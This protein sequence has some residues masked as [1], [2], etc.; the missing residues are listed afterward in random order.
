MEYVL[1]D[2]SIYLLHE[3]RTTC[4]LLH[5][6]QLRGEMFTLDSSVINILN[7]TVHFWRTAFG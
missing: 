1:I 6:F 4:I 2:S 5:P 3:M 7:T